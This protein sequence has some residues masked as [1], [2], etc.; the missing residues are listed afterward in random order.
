MVFGL[1]WQF[2]VFVNYWLIIS[3]DC[4]NDV[5]MYISGPGFTCWTIRSQLSMTS[6]N[7]EECMHWWL[8]EVSLCWLSITVPAGRNELIARYIKL[9]TGKA[10]TRKQ[11]SCEYSLFMSVQSCEVCP[12]TS[13]SLAVNIVITYVFQTDVLQSGTHSNPHFCVVGW[14]S[15]VLT[16]L[17]TQPLYCYS[18]VLV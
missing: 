13:V 15:H 11:V 16:E 5:T 2:S 8:A 10:R 18:L 3:G 9:R 4:T 1:Y 12:C 14:A 7:A 17:K 6:T